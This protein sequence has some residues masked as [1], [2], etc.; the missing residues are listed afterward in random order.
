MQ[1]TGGARKTFPMPNIS[2]ESKD[3][4]NETIAQAQHWCLVRRLAVGNFPGGIG[5]NEEH[6]EGSHA[7]VTKGRVI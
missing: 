3:W 6:V 7:R 1:H 5:W 2:A 4:M